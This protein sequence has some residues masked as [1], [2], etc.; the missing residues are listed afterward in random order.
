MNKPR[1]T[2]NHLNADAL[3]DM[4]GFNEAID[5]DFGAATDYHD[6]GLSRR[7]WLQLMGASLALGG[8]TGCRYEEETIAP[9]AF[10]PQGRI[11]GIPEKFAT[12]LDYG[13]V[14]QPLIST[15]Y[16][17][18]PI[19]LDGS[20]DHPGSMGG[21][22]TFT[23][24]RMLEFYD[25]DRLRAPLKAAGK[26]DQQVETTWESL[27]D[28]FGKILSK[29]DLSGVA[30][31]A[32]PTSSPSLFRL[33][34]E[35]MKK[36][37]AW[38]TYAAV[39]DDNTRE[40]SK[41]AFGKPHR[42]TYALDKAKV[43]VALD[44]D[45][46][47]LDPAGIANSFTFAMGRDVDSGNGMSRLYSIESQFSVTGAA[48][49]HRLALPSQRIIEFVGALAEAVRAG[50]TEVDKSLPYREKMLAAIASDLI[51]NKGNGVIVA[52]ERQP[53]IVH[54]VVHQLNEELGNIGETVL[55]SELPDADRVST[56]DSI[57]DLANQI[58]GGQI[59]SLV[60]LGGNPVYD[61][62]RS[63]AFGS[64]IGKL[65]H[66][67]HISS[68]NNETSLKCQWVSAMAHPLE[69]WQ[70]GY[71]FDGSVLIGQ[72]LINP[73][74]G[75][76]SD[77]ETLSALMGLEEVDSQQIVQKTHELGESEWQQAVH[78]GF[79]ADSAA[80]A[81]A[82]SANKENSIEDF[83]DWAKPWDGESVEIVFATSNSVYDGRHANNSW[84]QELPDFFTK[85]SWDNVVSVSPA[86]GKKLGLKQGKLM[87]LKLNGAEVSLPVNIQPGQAD[88]SVGVEIGYG[89]T[90]A[91]RVG[92]DEAKNIPSIGVDVSP[93]RSAENWLLATG[94]K[95][96][97]IQPTGTSYK[98]ALV[99]EPWTI[100]ATGRDEIQARM[101]RD[102]DKSETKRSAL[103]RE[104]SFE[105]YSEFLTKHPMDE[106]HED[107][108]GGH[109][110]GDKGHASLLKK[111]QLPVIGQVSFTRPA[112]EEADAKEAD[113]K[114]AHGD[115]D[116]HDG[117]GHGDHG[118][119]DHDDHGHAAHAPQWPEAFHMHH[120]LFDLTPGVRQSY[121]NEDPK[122]YYGKD[123]TTTNIWGMS[124]DLNKCTG[125]N[126]CVIACQSENNIPVVGKADVWRGREMHWMRIDRYYGDNLYTDSADEGDKQIV[127]QPVTCHHCENAPCETVCPVAATVH[128]SEGLND[129]VYN[130][131]IGTRY[132]GNNCPY[133]VRRFNFFN[134]ADAK[135][136]LKYPGADKL[137]PGDR[138]LQHL[139]MNPEVTVRT[140]GVMEKCT[141]CVQRIQN[142]KIQANNEGRRPIGPNEITT[143]C[144]DACPTKAIKFGDLHNAE[145]D[146]A[147]AH[148]NPRAYVM[149]EELNNRPR[150]KYLAR[151]RNVHPA[152]MEFDDRNSIPQYLHGGHNEQHDHHEGE[153]DHDH[154][155]EGHD[156]DEH[157]KDA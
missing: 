77:L 126:S 46:L 53:P 47:G 89:R 113:A 26:G 75:G 9:F 100:D 87:T 153:K 124:I 42:A 11:P 5:H 67:L 148:A 150:T 7:R 142:T 109:G 1:N 85:I 80:K 115:G 70:D 136:F 146:V 60:M 20:P 36:G 23:Q 155:H 63:L 68:V 34:R 31:L 14:A 156:H 88:G 49:D 98:L 12:M 28:E 103:L 10:R 91:G 82:P 62:P 71:A 105:S 59:K 139:M 8:A 24:A 40:G 130:R 35:F 149:L 41:L 127:H 76:K 94:L 16:D 93:L 2:A 110:D 37:G 90:A 65:D 140:R 157:D 122:K 151:V 55:L 21:S 54:A 112:D 107:H 52:G 38:F 13:G 133:K 96:S 128:S 120:E 121:A 116:S 143:A 102:A 134:Y 119:G 22:S 15:N 117:E 43:I 51:E 111:G 145:S 147:K 135:T 72:R 152:L 125:C 3:A 18:R 92:G 138:D 118:H 48:A 101:F 27:S 84:L 137:Q 97:V 79:I 74:F 114:E 144:Q 141:Y 6:D 86:T 17:G 106:S 81:A 123:P 73:L 32:E 30:I 104:G 154:D 45:I 61:A 78:D 19:K 99:Q 56:L 64:L 58:E 108:G 57:T 95:S 44:A 129:M 69:S 33:Q 66:S 29:A 83:S 131:C 4:P 50:K 25:P 132:C 39:A